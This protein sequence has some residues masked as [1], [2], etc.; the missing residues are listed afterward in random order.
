MFTSHKEYFDSKFIAQKDMNDAILRER[1]AKLVDKFES[2]AIAINKAETATEKRFECV[3]TSTPILCADLIWRPA[4]ELQVNDPIIAL[5]EDVPDRRGRRF[6]LAYVTENSIAED[7]LY[8]VKTSRGIIKCNGQHLWLSRENQRAWAGWKWIKT[9]DLTT[10]HE[11]NCPLDVWEVSNSYEAGWLA[12][13]F[14][15]EGCL[16]KGKGR[17]QLSITQRESLTSERIEKTLRQWTDRICCH[18][19]SFEGKKKQKQVIYHFIISNR[20]EILK[21]IG[22]VRPPRL[23]ETAEKAWNGMVMASHERI[24]TI[25]S[26]KPIGVGKIARLSTSTHTYIAEGFAMHNSVNE[27][28]TTLSDQQRTFLTATEYKSAHQNLVDLVNASA[29]TTADTILTQKE[30]IDKIENMKTGGQSTW[31]MIVGIVAFISALFS[32]ALHFIK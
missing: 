22:S 3:E 29:K 4:G 18:R 1:D 31:M 16:S 13:M 2:L 17:V 6:R 28:R 15:G 14:D 32:I 8:E 27:F 24:T 11:V 26:V 21:I 12:G 10:G 9:T 7:E 23:L 30:R 19:S 20:P 25:V 5:D